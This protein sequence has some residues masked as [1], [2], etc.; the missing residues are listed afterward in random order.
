LAALHNMPNTIMA[1]RAADTF[2][3]DMFRRVATM[4]AATT[5]RHGVTMEGGIMGHRSGALHQGA[6]I[7]IDE[8]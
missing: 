2:P 3:G 4:V 8:S 5:R 1:H 7:A 6:I